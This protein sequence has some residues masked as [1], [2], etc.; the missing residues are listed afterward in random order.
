MPQLL[1]VLTALIASAVGVDLDRGQSPWSITDDHDL[2]RLQRRHVDCGCT[3]CI[4]GECRDDSECAT[5]APIIIAVVVSLLVIIGGYKVYVDYI[6]PR[7]LAA[8]ARAQAQ[9][10]PTQPVTAEAPA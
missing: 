4:N 9:A 8:Q 1:V 10:Q 7:R 3:C 5:L 6:K 2:R